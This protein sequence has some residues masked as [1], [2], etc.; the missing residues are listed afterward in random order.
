MRILFC[1][2][3]YPPLGGGGGVT[4]SLLAQELAKRHEVTVLTSQAFGL[5]LEKSEGRVKVVRV[6]VF[7]RRKESVAS[8]L[9]MATFIPRAIQ[10]GRKLLK[11][12]NYDLINTHFVLP[13]G[14]VGD[15]LSRYG[16]VPN[17]LFLHGGDLYDP[18]KSTSPHRHLL[19][20]AWIRMLLK[21]ADVVAAHSRDVF[22][23]ARRFYN[24][25]I[26]GVQIP[27]MIKKP[28]IKKGCREQYGCKADETLLVA[29]GRL[30]ARKAVDQL[31]LLMDSLGKERTRLIIIGTGPEEQSLKDEVS[32]RPLNNRILF[33]GHLP[34]SEKLR[35]LQMCDIYV[36]SSQ[37]EGFGLV[38]LEAMAAGLPI[39]CYDKGG[40]TDFL[41]DNSTGFVVPLNDLKSF[42]QRCLRL[43]KDRALR[44][45]MG[46]Y[47][48]RLV[49]EFFVEN[50][51]KR[52]E[53]HFEELVYQ[54]TR[55]RSAQTFAVTPHSRKWQPLP[56]R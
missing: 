8:L 30:V 56:R 4:T 35:I 23:C 34:E 6:P 18:S 38:F 37:H 33:L 25:Q 44:V 16:K 39:I 41:A 9:S 46:Q 5:P 19:L 51:A 31:I 24:P 3:E 52:Y 7:F 32:K 28:P 12:N 50:C 45:G 15:A 20:R 55:F 21:R 27:A 47:N 1:N 43:I 48:L 22:E 14:P 10:R 54:A 2:Y 36:S 26:E 40:H 29:V 13:S 42:G 11:S 49:K 53:Y 17:L